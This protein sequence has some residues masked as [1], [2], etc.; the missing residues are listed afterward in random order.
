VSDITGLATVAVTGNYADLVG[1]PD[2]PGGQLPDFVLPQD[3][4]KVLTIDQNEG[5]AWKTPSSINGE[6]WRTVDL[7]AL[8]PVL[9]QNGVKRW[10]LPQNLFP[11]Y[12]DPVTF[13]LFL[14]YTDSTSYSSYQVLISGLNFNAKVVIQPVR[15]RAPFTN[16]PLTIYI[17]YDYDWDF[18]Q[19]VGILDDRMKILFA[20]YDQFFVSAWMARKGDGPFR[21]VLRLPKTPFIV[22]YYPPFQS[23][24]PPPP[25]PDIIVDNNT[26]VFFGNLLSISNE[27]TI[28]AWSNDF[29][30]GFS[31]SRGFFRVPCLLEE[32]KPR[33]SAH[34]SG[35]FVSGNFLLSPF[36]NIRITNSS[37]D[38][39][40]GFQEETLVGPDLREMNLTAAF[41]RFSRRTAS[42]TYQNVTD[43]KICV[44]VETPLSGIGTTQEDWCEVRLINL[45]II[46]EID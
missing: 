23:P 30:I 16:T 38:P 24:S 6:L 41:N 46:V 22:R 15:T 19:E 20:K 35:E 42:L 27:S 37:G 31:G 25:E 40:G 28:F 5:L 36:A 13:H 3:D 2:N 26:N 9:D 8:P 10:V 43:D 45:A 29:N 14:R 12:P 11:F 32:F 7:D 34:L 39:L 17:G 21:I 4:G 44:A 33:V 1:A 18:A